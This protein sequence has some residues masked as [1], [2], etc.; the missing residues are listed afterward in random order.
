MTVGPAGTDGTVYF[1]ATHQ[2][3][4]TGAPAPITGSFPDYNVFTD[5]GCCNGSPPDYNDV[6][7]LVH[8]ER[9]RTLSCIPNPVDRGQDVSCKLTVAGGE[10]SGWTFTGRNG[11]NTADITI[12]PTF[13]ATSLEWTGRA[14]TSGSVKVNFTVNGAPDSLTTSYAVKPRTWTWVRTDKW[15]YRAGI[16]QPNCFPNSKYQYGEQGG[17]G[18]WSARLGTCDGIPV[19]PDPLNE[20]GGYTL[21]TVT[22]GPN[23][24]QSYVLSVDYRMDTESN[25]NPAILP[26]NPPFYTLSKRDSCKAKGVTTADLYDFNTKCKLVDVSLNI[27]GLWNH[28]GYGTDPVM[29]NGHQAQL[30]YYASQPEGDL[31]LRLEKLYSGSPDILDQAV[32]LEARNVATSLNIHWVNEN[33]ISRTNYCGKIW[34][35][36]PDATPAM[37]VQSNECY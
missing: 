23:E 34:K 10:V 20:A 13:G 15:S 32:N 3:Y 6:I 37:F 24:G 19:S 35:W 22:N 11:S 7:L 1:T 28:E 29:R 14:V 5:D 4:G 27:N 17:V 31:Y 8:V 33:A 21:Y 9:D 25:L 26:G 12:H 2:E 18:G 16:G 36:N 30:E